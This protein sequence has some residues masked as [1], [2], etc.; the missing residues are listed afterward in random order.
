VQANRA[1]DGYVTE[2]GERERA[3][4]VSAFAAGDATTVDVPWNREARSWFVIDCAMGCGM[5][6]A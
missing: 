2:V 6:R 1:D 4:I 5:W 3:M